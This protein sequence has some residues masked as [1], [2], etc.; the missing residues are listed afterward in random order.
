VF[1]PFIEAAWTTFSSNLQV[2]SIIAG[3]SQFRALEL[4]RC[5]ASVL[6]DLSLEIWDRD[7]TDGLAGA[8]DSNIFD[9]IARF[10]DKSSST[11]R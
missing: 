10:T 2:M 8:D 3:P 9:I 1:K 6:R 11:L 4:P 7:G 5:E